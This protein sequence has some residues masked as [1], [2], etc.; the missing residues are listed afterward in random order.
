M[1]C[2]LFE[3]Y[4]YT[5]LCELLCNFSHFQTIIVV[6]GPPGPPGE[7]GPEGPVGP[8]GYIGETGEPGQPGPRGK[9]VRT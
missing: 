7:P 1:Y 4:T 8:K 6:Y 2:F 9:R 3:D 5:N